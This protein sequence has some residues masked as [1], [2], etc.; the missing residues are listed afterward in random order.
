MLYPPPYE[1][2]SSSK[3]L[4]NSYEPFRILDTRMEEGLRGMAEEERVRM[5]ESEGQGVNG[6]TYLSRVWALGVWN[7]V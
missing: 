5:E 4:P 2:G 7:L 1:S 3:P 6:E